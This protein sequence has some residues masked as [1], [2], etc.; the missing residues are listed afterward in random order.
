MKSRNFALSQEFRSSLGWMVLEILT[1]LAKMLTRARSSVG[2][3]GARGSTPKITHSHG[4]QV[5][6]G[7][8]QEA[9]VP[10]LVDLHL[11]LLDLMG[12][13]FPRVCDP[14]QKLQCFRKSQIITSA[15]FSWSHR[16][17]HQPWYMVG[18]VYTRLWLPRGLVTAQD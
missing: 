10:C 11:A 4:W 5:G 12:L 14:R 17:I 7:S 9:S 8:C 6:V 13:A 18:E 2:V 16:P 1:W 15:V 3:T